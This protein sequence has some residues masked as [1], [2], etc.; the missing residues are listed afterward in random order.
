VK[1]F[2]GL[3]FLLFGLA[4]TYSIGAH[5]SDGILEI[6]HS[7]A[8]SS[9]CFPGDSSGY[10]V[11]INAR[12]SYQ[13]TGNLAPPNIDTTAIEITVDDVT[14]D[15]AGFAI[16]FPGNGCLSMANCPQG[17]GDG[18]VGGSRTTVR[19]GF[20]RNAGRRGV[21]LSGIAT[22]EAVRVEGCGENGIVLGPR[23]I[24]LRSHV[25]SCGSHGVSLGGNT[26]FSH[27]V[28]GF[29]NRLQNG[30]AD[31]TGGLAVIG[32]VC[33]DDSCTHRMVRRY[34]LTT[35]EYTG[36]EV[37][38]FLV[39]VN[40]FHFASYAELIESGS[41]EY[42]TTLGLTQDD[43][44][45]GPPT[46]IGWI[47]SGRS[48]APNTNCNNWVSPSNSHQGTTLT[49]NGVA[50]GGPKTDSPWTRDFAACDSEHSVWCIED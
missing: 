10:P 37:T 28:F 40:G 17:T 8:V 29:N 44:R 4:A 16:V 12:G 35:S 25:N 32:N 47:A 45:A 23:S 21:S 38:G 13:L 36:D 27:N 31:R 50:F 18:V 6:N 33:A 41:L 11:T 39:C 19:D 49:Y 34:Y 14:L 48:F 20:I 26:T 3:R 7:C 9:G 43:S 1:T 15:L 22:V 24:L 2:R 30:S 5:S 46:I 42:D